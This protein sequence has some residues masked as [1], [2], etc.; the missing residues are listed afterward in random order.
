MPLTETVPR[1][2]A[3]RRPPGE[4]VAMPRKPYPVDGRPPY[5]NQTI[6]NVEYHNT[7][8]LGPRQKVAV[9]CR[10]DDDENEHVPPPARPVPDGSEGPGKGQAAAREESRRNLDVRHKKAEARRRRGVG[11][12]RELYD[13]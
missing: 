10:P 11:R 3:R 4:D 7:K 9:R 5:F 12:Q 6:I 1:Y 8:T 2:D 13:S